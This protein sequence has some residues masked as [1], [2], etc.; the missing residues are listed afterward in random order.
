LPAGTPLDCP[1]DTVS[2]STFAS[3]TIS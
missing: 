3:S 2:V 1:S